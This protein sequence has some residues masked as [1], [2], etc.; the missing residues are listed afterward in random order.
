MAAATDA[1]NDL[2]SGD[3]T[4]IAEVQSLALTIADKLPDGLNMDEWVTEAASF[5]EG[6]LP[7]AAKFLAE[8]VGDLASALPFAGIA[9]RMASQ[10]FARYQALK[11]L[12]E[13]T[14]QSN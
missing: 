14:K 4:I 8:T 5:V 1:I 11:E 12:E 10:M 9:V 7:G 6:A 2:T 13:V 3:S